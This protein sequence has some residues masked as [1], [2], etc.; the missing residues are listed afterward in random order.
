M[1]RLRGTAPEGSWIS[2]YNRDLGEG[3]FEDVV[4]QRYD[5]ELRAEVGHHIVL[6]YEI[7]GDRSLPLELEIRAPRQ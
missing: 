1:V 7:G 2:A 4:D 5:I 6:W 3:T